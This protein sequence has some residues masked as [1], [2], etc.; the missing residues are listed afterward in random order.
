M[1]T[2]LQY[3]IYDVLLDYGNSISKKKGGQDMN[4]ELKTSRYIKPQDMGR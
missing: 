3:N 4:E 1:E 2:G